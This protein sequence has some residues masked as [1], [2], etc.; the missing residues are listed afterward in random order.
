MFAMTQYLTATPVELNPPEKCARSFEFESFIRKRLFPVS[1][2]DLVL[3]ANDEAAEKNDYVEAVKEPHFRF[4]S[5]ENGLEFF[6][7]AKFTFTFTKT[8]IQWCKQFELKR[9]QEVD[10]RLPVYFLI[11]CGPS[12]AAPRQ[13][14][15]FPVR[16]VRFNK[17]LRTNIEK[18]KISTTRGVDEKDLL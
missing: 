8:M 4:K 9:Y 6:V 18:Y 16:N 7:D 5:H 14:Y 1:K 11:G 17:V 12:P 3:K 2:Y 10:T 15:F 13:V